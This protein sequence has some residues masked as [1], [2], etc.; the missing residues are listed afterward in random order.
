MIYMVYL[1]RLLGNKIPLRIILFFSDNPSKYFYA[2]E[3]RKKLKI[4]K[5]S[6][7]KWLA[8]LRKTNTLLKKR[9]GN[10]INYKINIEH[11]LVKQLRILFVIAELENI[12]KL[13]F[14]IQN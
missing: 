2:E 10:T 8:V 3:L 6:L 9:I 4:S 12:K 13:N 1:N 5:A 14:N 11:P 7:F